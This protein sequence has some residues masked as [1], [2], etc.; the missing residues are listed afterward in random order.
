MF[1]SDARRVVTHT[2]AILTLVV[3]AV[4]SYKQYQ[5]GTTS[6]LF[7]NMFVSDSMSDLLKLFSYLAQRPP[8]TGNATPVIHSASGEERNCTQ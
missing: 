8:S 4:L 6:Y 1:V 7:R 5:T 2:L 3:C